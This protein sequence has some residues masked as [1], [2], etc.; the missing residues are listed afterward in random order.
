MFYLNV[1]FLFFRVVSYLFEI[2]I[3]PFVFLISVE[4]SIKILFS[5]LVSYLNL[6]IN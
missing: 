4:L 5:L 1:F 2:N 3:I 6:S